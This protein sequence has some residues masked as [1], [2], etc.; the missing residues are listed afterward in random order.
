MTCV[1]NRR[2]SY[3]LDE[4]S[5]KWTVILVWVKESTLYFTNG[6]QI[7]YNWKGAVKPGRAQEFQ[8]TEPLE[9]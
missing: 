6:L 2:N 7:H 8:T 9:C 5:L 3:I 4:N 1:P